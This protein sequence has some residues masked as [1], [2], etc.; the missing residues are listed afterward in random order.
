MQGSFGLHPC[1]TPASPDK[2]TNPFSFS[3]KPLNELLCLPRLTATFD[4]QPTDLCIRHHDAKSTGE[5]ADDVCLN[6]MPANDTNIHT[7][8]THD[9]DRW[10]TTASS[11][12]HLSAPLGK[13][14]MSIAFHVQHLKHLLGLNSQSLGPE[15]SASSSR[16]KTRE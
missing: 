10:H 5:Q 8:I 1:P 11:R 2:I 6:T 13:R 4:Y 7:A 15:L 12:R 16:Q 9:N 3:G 14:L